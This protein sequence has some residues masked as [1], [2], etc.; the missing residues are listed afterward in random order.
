MEMLRK[1]KDSRSSAFRFASGFPFAERLVTIVTSLIN[2]DFAIIKVSG[3]DAEIFLHRQSSNEVLNLNPGQG[4]YLSFLTA[5]G[6]IQSLAYLIK[7]DTQPRTFQ[8][9]VLSTNAAQTIEHLRKFAIVEE[10][11]LMITD[12]HL[13]KETAET[14]T[15]LKN[16][17]LD[18]FA[19]GD[20]L[21]KLNLVDKYASLSK[22]CF[23]GQEVLA[24]FS[25]IGLKKR[26][27][28]SQDYVNKALETFA[29]ADKNSLEDQQEANKQAIDLLRQAIKEDPKNEDAY[30]ALGVILAKEQKFAEAIKVMEQLE[31]INPDSIMAQTNL[32]IFY[33]K[34]NNKEKAEE[35]KAKGTVLQF[36]KALHS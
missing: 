22:G 6:K 3:P 28:R 36:N 23:P 18:S 29:K 19:E 27:Q 20:T 25:N 34:L 31:F 2:M 14:L 17:E 7:L 1:A 24:K 33:M 4:I 10:I 26:S 5:Q 13:N 11:E 12:N 32:S 16:F 35:H 8:L 30:E 9:F 15:G 21:I